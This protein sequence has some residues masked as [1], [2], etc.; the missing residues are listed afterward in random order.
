MLTLL[1]TLLVI[2]NGPKDDLKHMEGTWVLVSTADGPLGEKLTRQT[3]RSFKLL[4]K[5]STIKGFQGEKTGTEGT[6]TLDSTKNPR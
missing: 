4:V 6:F 3:D 5:G 2:A 1:T